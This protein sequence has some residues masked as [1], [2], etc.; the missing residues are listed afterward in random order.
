MQELVLAA[1]I[2]QG[3]TAVADL[4]VADALA[5]GPLPLDELATAVGADPDALGRLLRALI[6][7]GIFARRDDGRYELTS[8]AE[9]LR[10]DVPASM[11]AMARFVGS[12]QH[13]EH[14]SLLTDAIR[15]GRSG[16]PALRG[17][18]FFDYLGDEPEFAQIFNDAMTGLSGLSIGPVVDAYDFTRFGTIVDVAGGH[19]RLL[20]AILAS[21]PSAQGVLYD[22]PEVIAG[23]SALL[24][25][26]DVAER[27]RLAEGSFFD[28]VPAGGDAYVLKHIIHDWDD[29]PSVR[30]LRNVRSA[31]A[32]GATLLLVET[33]IPEDDSASVAKWVDMEM[34]VINDGRERT[35]GEYRRLFDEAGFAMTGVIDT[36]SRFSIIEGRAV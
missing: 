20:A 23:A 22:L 6:T 33:V 12:R 5:A 21:A 28:G 35:A 9:Q 34:L 2:S 1:W 4:R 16:V 30:I 10:S 15:T 24:R 17:K 13:R 31:A 29:E 3:I 25:E 19:G 36:A 11:A 7:K 14:W 8:L 32:P 26:N 18:D 27:V